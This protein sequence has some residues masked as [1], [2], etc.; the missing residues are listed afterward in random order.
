MSIKFRRSTGGSR[1]A[2]RRASGF[3]IAIILVGVLLVVGLRWLG[4]DGKT[5]I[6]VRCVSPTVFIIGSDTTNYA[7]LASILMQRVAKAKTETD[8][9][10][11]VIRLHIPKSYS[12]AQID[13]ILQ[14][15]QAMHPIFELQ[16]AD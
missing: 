16:L 6:K 1:S 7:Q 10:Q 8:S 4:G 14:L 11:I 9:A 13:D 15:T 5:Y 3:I 12:V 2:G